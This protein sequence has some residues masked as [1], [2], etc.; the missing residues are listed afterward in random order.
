MKAW[1]IN[2]RDHC[3]A[4]FF[5]VQKERKRTQIV[6]IKIVIKCEQKKN[7]KWSCFILPVLFSVFFAKDF[8]NVRKF[9]D[10]IHYFHLSFVP[11][12]LHIER[13]GALKIAPHRNLVVLLFYLIILSL[14]VR[15][16][17]L[18]I[19]NFFSS[20][21]HEYESYAS[22]KCTCVQSFTQ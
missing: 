5:M 15:M 2:S 3:V 6:P 16:L 13:R 10:S 7:I 18:Y 12:L 4:H 21:I 1:I 22:Y 19:I 20:F 8:V 9:S 17:F 11:S 14:Y